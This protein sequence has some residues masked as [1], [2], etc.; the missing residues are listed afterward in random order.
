MTHDLYQV[1]AFTQEPFKGNPAAVCL[2]EGPQSEDWMQALA[3]EMN[4]SETAFLL[5]E[6]Q[7]WRLRW[8]TPTTEVDLCGHATLAS[9]FVLFETHPA[10][11]DSP[12]TFLTRSGPLGAEWADG[13]IRLD[14]PRMS[15]EPIPVEPVVVSALGFSPVQA[16]RSGE[17]YLFEARDAEAVLG[18][19]PDF[20]LL[21][22][23]PM[24]EVIITAQSPEPPYDFISR[25]FAPR[26]GVDEDPVTG[27]AH[28]LLA[29]FWAK[30]LQKDTFQAYQASSRGGELALALMENRVQI[31]GAAHIVFKA[32]VWV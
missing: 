19:E 28:C 10:L 11:R 16:V 8:F 7:K 15:P 20:D 21:E 3:A 1:D 2:L 18:A 31:T 30:R 17:Y 25:F 9:A 4:L 5:P 23:L 13:R 14:F 26:L 12:L 29:P 22:T 24:P 32:T 6:G 27:S